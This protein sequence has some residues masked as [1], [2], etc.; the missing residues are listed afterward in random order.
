M[1]QR[2][3]FHDFEPVFIQWISPQ[4]NESISDY[5]TRLLPQI[6]EENPIIIGLSFGGMV[7]VEI[8]KQIKTTKIILISSAKNT[9]EIPNLY[10]F[11]AFLN[12]NKLIPKQ[13]FKQSN[14]FINWLFGIKNKEDKILLKQVLKDTDLDF[15]V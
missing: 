7:A 3:N 11:A 12:L 6:S 15:T 9:S 8:S 10:K 2:L 1:F 4:K 13:L 14:F 5:A